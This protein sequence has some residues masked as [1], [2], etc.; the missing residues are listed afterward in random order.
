M[1]Q[2]TLETT[3][4]VVENNT[5]HASL[6]ETVLQENA[7]Q[8]RTIVVPD[9]VQALRYLRQSGD[10]HEAKRPDL[11]LLDLN[12]PQKDGRDVLAEIKADP[13][14]KRIPIVILTAASDEADIFKSYELQG[15]CYVIKSQDIAQLSTVVRRIKDFWL[16]VVTLP[17]SSGN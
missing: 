5:N 7:V 15:N 14:L 17:S 16:G 12:L 1:D 9:G 6:I 2:P 10:F 3:I 8:H 13:S 11:I 4:L